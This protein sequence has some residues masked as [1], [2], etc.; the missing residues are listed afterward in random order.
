MSAAGRS[1]IA[2]ASAFHTFC[3]CVGVEW[4]GEPPEVDWKCVWTRSSTLQSVV[5]PNLNVTSVSAPSDL[6]LVVAAG[7]S[8]RNSHSV[9]FPLLLRLFFHT[10]LLQHH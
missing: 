8:A 6:A 5:F 3:V 9:T 1:K 7:I 2:L 10:C 4:G